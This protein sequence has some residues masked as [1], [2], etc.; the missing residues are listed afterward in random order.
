MEIKPHHT[1]TKTRKKCCEGQQLAI[2][3][4]TIIG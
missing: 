1:H 2:N 3:N 4:T